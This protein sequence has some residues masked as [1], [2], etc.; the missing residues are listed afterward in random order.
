VPAADLPSVPSGID[1]F[2]DANVFVYAFL[3]RSSQCLAVLERCARE[4]VFGVTS[5]DTVNDV[6]HRMMLAEA[7]SK[8]LISR[9][10]A[11]LLK[12]RPIVVRA[13]T[14]Y[15][16][17]TSR[18]FSLNIL[19]LE[20]DESL[21]RG[22][23]RVRSESGLMTKDSLIVSTMNEYAITSIATHDRDFLRVEHLMVYR[24]TDI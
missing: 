20:S 2:I 6:T 22:S 3:R 18:I 8:G 21:L 15:W 4:E 12:S 11:S 1:L 5:F 7:M 13:L 24:P 14:D 19:L 9:E 10:N 16:S 23:Q 17:Y